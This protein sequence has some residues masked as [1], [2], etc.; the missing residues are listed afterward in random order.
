MIFKSN[1]P[2]ERSRQLTGCTENCFENISSFSVA[3]YSL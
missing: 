1:N 3:L 2:F